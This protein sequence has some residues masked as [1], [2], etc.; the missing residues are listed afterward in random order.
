[1]TRNLERA[2][3]EVAKLPE[4]E[5]DAIA[6]WLLAELA[7]ERAWEDAFAGSPDRLAELG[8]GARREH[9]DGRTEALDPDKL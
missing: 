3:A 5:Q 9:R 4:R 2:F 8:A 6:Q 7:S 1:M